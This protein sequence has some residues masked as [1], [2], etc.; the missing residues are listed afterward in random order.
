MPEGK[1]GAGQAKV[2]SVNVDRHQVLLGLR[3]GRDPWVQTF[4]LRNPEADACF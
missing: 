1:P 3:P 2:G 4:E